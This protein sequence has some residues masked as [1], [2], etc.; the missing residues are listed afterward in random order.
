M[1]PL[2]HNAF[3][4]RHTPTWFA[5]W[6]FE[7]THRT[8]CRRYCSKWR[9]WEL[10]LV[11]LLAQVGS[12][13]MWGFNWCWTQAACATSRSICLSSDPAFASGVESSLGGTSCQNCGIT[14]SQFSRTYFPLALPVFSCSAIPRKG[15]VRW[16]DN[17]CKNEHTWKLVKLTHA[18]N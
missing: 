3:H 10:L 9:L 18:G 17:K 11:G 6:Y 16:H 7:G 1:L 15:R 12:Y 2:P 14:L 4:I 5:G 13:C 8:E